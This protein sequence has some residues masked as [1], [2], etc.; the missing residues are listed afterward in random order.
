[1]SAAL[2]FASPAHFR[3]WLAANA[4]STEGVWLRLGKKGGAHQLI[5]YAQALDQALCFGWIDGHKKPLD[6]HSWLQRFSRRRARSM[7]SARNVEHVARLTA[8]KQ[9]TEHG[10]AEVDAARADGRWAKAYAPS[11]TSTVPAELVAELARRPKARAFFDVLTRANRY[12]I[13]FRLQTA[14]KPETRARRLALVLEMLEQGKT[15]HPQKVALVSSSRGRPRSGKS[16][17]SHGS[18]P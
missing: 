6:E 10:Q 15:F 9:M 1:M 13:I 3:R 16:S 18:K 2:E 5:N 4:T 7:W 17:H 11:S 8:A 12:A 14:K